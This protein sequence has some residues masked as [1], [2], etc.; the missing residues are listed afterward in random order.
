MVFELNRLHK[1]SLKWIGKI[2]RNEQKVDWTLSRIERSAPSQW[3]A[4]CKNL[5]VLLQQRPFRSVQKTD[6]VY[7]EYEVR[8]KNELGQTIEIFDLPLFILGRQRSIALPQGKA[9]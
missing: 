7:P 3:E 5:Y 9:H 6:Q 8:G 1:C 2:K 4:L